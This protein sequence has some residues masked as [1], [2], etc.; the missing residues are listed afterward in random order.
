MDNTEPK[1]SEHRYNSI[2]IQVLGLLESLQFPR[3]SIQCVP[4][5]GLTGANIMNNL[6]SGGESRSTL[7]PIVK[8][9]EVCPWYHG[10]TLLEIIDGLPI[11]EPPKSSAC[12]LRAVVSSV[13]DSQKG[14]EALV[15]ILRGKLKVGHTV[16][17]LGG[18][19][20]VATVKSIRAGHGGR[21]L[22]VLKEREQAYVSFVNRFYIKYLFLQKNVI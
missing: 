5:S 10:E 18:P 19:D 1:W 14:C 21:Q 16:G 22:G 3:F 2:C 13:L 12:S 4:V 8:M 7:A 15:K 17:Y 11:V 20:G 9:S 6:V